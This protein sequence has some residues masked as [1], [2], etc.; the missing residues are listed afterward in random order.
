MLTTNNSCHRTNNTAG[1]WFSGND[2]NRQVHCAFSG[3][4]QDS[5][6][7]QG[8][9]PFKFFI[10]LNCTPHENKNAIKVHSLFSFPIWD[11]KFLIFVV[12]S[13]PVGPLQICSWPESHVPKQ[14]DYSGGLTAWFKLGEGKQNMEPKLHPSYPSS[15]FPAVKTPSRWLLAGQCA[16]EWKQEPYYSYRFKIHL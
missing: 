6:L 1:I 16:T 8:H 12:T 15:P 3:F 5:S 7:S 14:C 11:Q 2:T 13:L 4:F 9:F 10:A